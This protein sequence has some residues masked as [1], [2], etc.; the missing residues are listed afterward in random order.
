M[1]IFNTKKEE[2]K[3]VKYTNVIKYRYRNTKNASM[4]I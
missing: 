2:K 4:Y 1:T 3:K